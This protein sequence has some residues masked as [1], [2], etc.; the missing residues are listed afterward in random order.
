[1]LSM[2]SRSCVAFLAQLSCPANPCTHVHFCCTALRVALIRSILLPGA[3]AGVTACRMSS[4]IKAM[5]GKGDS[6]A[7][8][9]SD[10]E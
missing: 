9:G 5:F 2:V 3:V 1:M 10:S 4:K 7:A 8:G 6:G